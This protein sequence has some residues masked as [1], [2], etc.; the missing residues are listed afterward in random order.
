MPEFLHDSCQKNYQNTLIVM[1]FARKINKS[2]EFH[3]IFARKMAE[4]HII[5]ARKIF[6]SEF[7]FFFGGGHLPPVPPVSYA[8]AEIQGQE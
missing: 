6:A 8:Y 4:F 2:P 7:F 5:I 1:I 3:T